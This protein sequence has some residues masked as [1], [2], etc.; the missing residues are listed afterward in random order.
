MK[1]WHRLLMRYDLLFFVNGVTTLGAKVV[2]VILLMIG[3]GLYAASLGLEGLE[4]LFDEDDPE[5]IG[6]IAVSEEK[7]R[8]SAARID[9][10]GD[11]RDMVAAKGFEPL[12]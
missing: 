3:G 2:I 12:T 11:G 5:A 4:A 10:V 9:V 8:S 6:A 7:Q 1:H